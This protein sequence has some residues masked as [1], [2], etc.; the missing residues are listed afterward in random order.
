[1][2][3]LDA[4]SGVVAALFAL[5]VIPAYAEEYQ[6]VPVPDGGT[7]TGSILLKGGPPPAKQYD[8][9]KFPNS[10]YCGKV[11]SDSAGHRL[12]QQ[13]N[14]GKHNAL[15]DVVVYLDV[16]RGKPFEFNWTGVKADGCRFLAQGPSTLAGVVVKK[17]EIRIENMD[18][19]PSD[20]KAAT[21]VLHNPHGYEVFGSRNSTLFNLPLPEKGQVIRKPVMLRQKE[22]VLKVECDQHNYMQ[23]FFHPVDN[24]Y[25]AVVS[26]DGTFQIDQIPPGEY[27]VHA[28]H[29]VLGKQEA[30][31]TVTAHG[32][33]KVDFTF[34]SN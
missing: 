32:Q 16:D 9:A 11:D 27:E 26:D 6:V 18:A 1:M 25:Y 17:K 10:G 12:V 22:S 2:I 20:P 24:P 3:H 21:G 15:K 4:K 23:V 34:A 33:A 29:P 8:L 7:V 13:V 31:V 5:S 19:D 14:V 28:W 30:T